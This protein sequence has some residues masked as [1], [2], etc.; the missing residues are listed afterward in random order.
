MSRYGMADTM[1][2]KGR[3]AS[4]IDSLW[5]LYISYVWS[6]PSASPAWEISYTYRSFHAGLSGNEG[7][8]SV[9][10]WL[11]GRWGRAQVSK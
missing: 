11:A 7:R 9:L 6:L 2:D 3:D 10:P 5:M 1:E 4:R 8:P